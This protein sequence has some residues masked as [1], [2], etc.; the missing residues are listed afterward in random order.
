MLLLKHH[1][2][3]E[4]LDLLI[5]FRIV[6]RDVDISLGIHPIHLHRERREV[7]Q[8][9]QPHLLRLLWKSHLPVEAYPILGVG[10]VGLGIGQ[11]GHTFP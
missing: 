3:Q 8:L 9:I 10:H 1:L 2:S 11:D 4:G 5:A 7:T 6:G